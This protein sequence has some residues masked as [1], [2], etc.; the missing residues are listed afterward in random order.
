MK[1]IKRTLAGLLAAAILIQVVPANALM[2]NAFAEEP[3]STQAQTDTSASSAAGGTAASST[4]TENSEA[5]STSSSAPSSSSEGSSAPASS[6]VTS[7]P[8][9]SEVNSESTSSEV[10][11]EA[12]SSEGEQESSAASDS[13][14]GEADP[15]AAEDEQVAVAA[16]TGTER[17]LNLSAVNSS[18]SDDTTSIT[19]TTEEELAKLSH[20]DPEKVQNL[21]ITLSRITG[22]I[23]LTGYDVNNNNNKNTT[24][25]IGLGTEEYPFRGTITGA[26]Q[27]YTSRAFFHVLSSKATI[28]RTNG[29]NWGFYWCGDGSAAMIADTY[30]LEGPADAQNQNSE[31]GTENATEVTLP[32]SVQVCTNGYNT[33]KTMGSLFGVVKAE[34]KH[35]NDTL[36][37]GN[38]ATY[39]GATVKATSSANA[40]LICGTLES[41]NITIASD[42]TLPDSYTVTASGSY[43]NS[44]DDKKLA[45]GNAGGLIG[46]MGAGTTLTVEGERTISAAVTANSGNAGGLVGLM[47]SGAKIVTASAQTSAEE[48]AEAQAESANKITLNTQIITGG[49]S[50]GGVV[51]DAADV[52]LDNAAIAVTSPTAKATGDSSN[53]GGLI[54]HY[55]ITKTKTST[56][57]EESANTAY[58]IPAGVTLETPTVSAGNGGN[59]GGYFGWLE[60]ANAEGANALSFTFGGTDTTTFNPTHAE[61]SENAYG[62]LAGKITSGAIANTVK[63]QN[64]T[65]TSTSSGKP[66]YHGGL[67]GELGAEGSPVYLETS[68][69][70]ITVPNPDGGDWF[71]GLVAILQKGSILNI[72]GETTVSTK[73]DKTTGT[74]SKGGGAVGCANEGSAVQLAGTTDFTGVNYTEESKYVQNVGW[75]LGNNNSALIYAK[76]SGSDSGWT[77][78]RPNKKLNDI[79]N[80]GQIIRLKAENASEDAKGLSSDL[81]QIDESSH[82]IQLNQ[83]TSVSWNNDITLSSADDFAL[84]SIAWN[85]RG[86]FSADSSFSSTSAN[87]K[88]WEKLK[89]KTIKLDDNIDLSGTGIL[90]L[91][92]DTYYDSKDDDTFTG[93][94]NGQSHT[95]TLAIGEKFGTYQNNGDGR[96][97]T[98]KNGDDIYHGALGIFAQVAGPTDENAA[99]IEIKNLTIKG[100]MSASN[101]S[102][103]FLMGGIAAIVKGNVTVSG[104]KTGDAV[105]SANDASNPENKFSINAY[106]EDYSSSDKYIIAGSL[107]GR[108]DSTTMTIQ[109][110]SRVNSEIKIHNLIKDNDKKD[111]RRDSKVMVGGVIGQG[112]GCDYTNK[113]N[114]IIKSKEYPNKFTIEDLTISGT[115]TAG[116][117]YVAGV[118]GFIGAQIGDID[119]NTS[120]ANNA[121]YHNITINKLKFDNFHITAN[122]V[123]AAGGGIMTGSTDNTL[124]GGLLASVL[125][126]TDVTFGDSTATS[127]NSNANPQYAL[128]VTGSSITAQNANGVGGLCYRASGKWTINNYGIDLSGLTIQA[129]KD[130]GLLV[131]RGEKSLQ[132]V[133]NGGQGK[134]YGGLYL[135]TTAYW[136][137]AYLVPTET[138]KISIT[139]SDGAFDEF[140]AYTS[141]QD[142]GKS[143]K[144]YNIMSN[145]VN[146]IVSIATQNDNNGNRKG[147]AE[148]SNGCTTYQNRT[149]YGK[150]HR[151]NPNSRYYYDL[152]QCYTDVKKDTSKQKNGYIDTPQELMLWSVYQYASPNIQDCFVPVKDSDIDKQ[153]ANGYIIGKNDSQSLLELDLKKYSYYPISLG[154]SLKIQNA[155]I[156][157][158]NEAIEEAETKQGSTNKT[159][160]GSTTGDA[161]KNNS[162]H[163]AM[164]C[165]LL[166]DFSASGGTPTLSVT[167][168]TFA[169]SVGQ[170]NGGSG[171]LIA[172][173][174]ENQAENLKINITLKEITLDGLIVT[175]YSD[176]N[177]APLLINKI[178]RR[179]HLSMGSADK[180]G[181]S[182][183]KDSYNNI[184]SAAAS[185]LIGD[186]GDATQGTQITM[187][188]QNIVLPD[189]P[190]SAGRTETQKG[191]FSR[192]TLL[193]S[194]SY[195]D[196]DTTCNATYNFYAKDDP[197]GSHHVTYGK[198]ITGT[199][200]FVDLQKWY[201]DEDKYEKDNGLVS[202]G[203]FDATKYLPYVHTAYDKTN[204]THEIKVNQRV[205]NITDGCGTYGHPYKITKPG[206]MKI[207]S[208]YMSTGKAR[209]EWKVTITSDQKTY[210]TDSTIDKTYQYLNGN[211]VQLGTDGKATSITLDNDAMLQ[212]LLNAYYT[213]EPQKITSEQSEGDGNTDSSASNVLTLPDFGGFGSTA[214]NP[215][216][217]VITSSSQMT[218]KLTGNSNPL[219][220]FSYGSVVKGLTIEYE[221]RE[222]TQT[223]TETEGQTTETVGKTLDYKNDANDNASRK[224][225]D[226]A[227]FGGVIGCVLGGDNIIDGVSVSI[228]SGWLTLTDTKEG[229]DKKHLIPVGGYV[230]EVAGG[231]VIFRNMASD[232]GKLSNAAFSDSSDIGTLDD[233]NTKYLYINPYV[234]RV[235]DGFAFY[236]KPAAAASGGTEATQAATGA[237]YLD[238]LENTD[239]N[240]KINTLTDAS[241]IVENGTVTPQNAQGLLV[242]SAIVNSGA[243][244]GGTSNAYSSTEKAS[245]KT[246]G[247]TPATTYTFV[248]YGKVRNAAY[249]AIGTAGTNAPSDF[250]TAQLDDLTNPQAAT[251]S[252]NLPYLITKY[253]TSTDKA[254]LFSLCE[255]TTGNNAPVTG[256]N[257]ALA[258]DGSFDMSGFGT[259]YQGIGGR[260]ASNAIQAAGT[261]TDGTNNAPASVVPEIASFNGNS[262]TVTLDMQV[263]EYAD[264]DF[265]AASVGGLFNLV[266]ISAN[267]TA[268]NLTIS[269]ESDTENS[270]VSLVYYDSA[271]T[272][273]AADSSWGNPAVVGV[274]GFAGS[275][276]GYDFQKNTSNEWCN[277]NRD[278][279]LQSIKLQ[280]LTVKGPASAG[281]ILGSTSR[282][283]PTKSDIGIM[284][285]K[286]TGDNTYC[287]I[288]YGVAFNDCSYSNITVTGK[289]AA[290]GFAGWLG[291]LDGTGKVQNS[292]GETINPESKVTVTNETTIAQSSAI[293][294]SNDGGY[295]GGLIGYSKTR[296]FVNMDHQGKSDGKKTT[297]ENVTVSGGTAAGGVIGYIAEKCYGIC[298]V[299]VKQT[300]STDTPSPLI[301]IKNSIQYF[302]SDKDGKNEDYDNATYAGG[303]VGWAKGAPQTWTNTNVVGKI[304]NCTLENV[305]INDA[306]KADTASISGS[307]KNTKVYI[308]GGMVGAVRGGET[309]LQS[310]TVSGGK[311]YGSITGG[312]AGQTDSTV[313]FDGCKIMGTAANTENSDTSTYAQIQG[314]STAGGVLGHANQGNSISV[315]VQS[316][317]VQYANIVGHDWGVGAWIGDSDS[318]KKGWTLYLFDSAVKDSTVSADGSK[319][320]EDY[321]QGRW[322]CGGGIIAKLRGPLVGS[323]IL[324]SNVTISVT[325][326]SQTSGQ[327]GLLFGTIENNQTVSIAG[328]SLQNIPKENKDWK[329][330]GDSNDGTDDIKGY[331]AFADYSGAALTAGTKDS[332]G[333]STSTAGTEK[334]LLGATAVSPYVVTNPKSGLH[335]W[336]SA[337]D[338]V[339]QKYLYGDGAYWTETTDSDSK[340]SY[341]T[342]A[343]KIWD[344]RNSDSG[345]NYAYKKF[346]ETGKDYSVTAFADNLIS[347][348]NAN[349]NPNEM[350][351]DNKTIK[352]KHQLD[353]DFPVLQVE[354]GNAAVVQNYLDI[355]TNGGFSAAN[356]L[357]TSNSQHVTASATVYEYKNGKLVKSNA[358]SA[359]TANTD[360]NGK[361]ILATTSDYDNT[362]DRFT[363]L[364]V[365]FTEGGHNYNVYVPIIVRR[366]LQVDFSATLS[367][368][369]N[370]REGDYT[371]LQSHVLESFGSTVTGYL[372]YT[373]NSE[374]GKFTEYGWQSYIDAGGDV[375]QGMGKVLR[376]A[377]DGSAKFPEGTQFTLVDEKT[378]KAYYYTAPSGGCDTIAFTSFTDST[379]STDENAKA[380]EETSIADLIG[381]KAEKAANG[382]FIQVDQDGKPTE[383]TDGSDASGTTSKPTVKIGEEYYRLAQGSE[384]GTHN[385]TVTERG[386]K[387]KSI[388]SESY[389]LVI[390]VPKNSGSSAING[391]LQTSLGVSVPKTIHYN[392]IKP[393]KDGNLQPDVHFNTAS[394]YQLSSGYVQELKENNNGTG[395]LLSGKNAVKEI[396]DSERNLYV[397]VVDTITFPNGQAYLDS[398]SEQNN[399][400]DELYLRIVG[401]L[402][403]TVKETANGSNTT[404]T[405][406]ETFPSGTTGTAEFYVYDD[407]NQYYKWDSTNNQ[408]I[409]VTDTD[410][411]NVAV[412]YTWTST[413]GNMELLLSEDGTTDNLISLQGVRKLVKGSSSD[414]S[415]T[416]HVRVKMTATIPASGIGV[417]PQSALTGEGPESY[418]KLVYT[419]QLSVTKD[420]LAYS[421]NRGTVSNTMIQYYRKQTGAETLT[422]TADSIDMLGINPLDKNQSSYMKDGKNSI[423]DTT[424]KYDL[425][426]LNNKLTTLKNSSGIQFTLTLQQKAA[427]KDSDYEAVTNA[428]EYMQVKLTS[429][430]AGKNE[431]VYDSKTGT[432][433]W[434]VK[435]DAY[436]DSETNALKETLGVFDTNI[437]TQNIQLLVDAVNVESLSHQY[438][439]YRVVLTAQILGSDEKTVGKQSQDDLI[440]TLAKIK[441]EFVEKKSATTTG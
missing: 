207:L 429:S 38:I 359:F 133:A 40:G 250:T 219:I 237:N 231:G 396:T 390:T 137:T 284:M 165:G 402:Q 90:G 46:A 431:L 329:L 172:G 62:G 79:G 308:T 184:A 156:H 153:P 244:S 389:F 187:T 183:E 316:C 264:D 325:K 339:T 177:Y 368:G 383:K 348:Y 185:S 242:L 56:E 170:I 257:I 109:D 169:G 362:R 32:V 319:Q 135:K 27:T 404:K 122:N 126:Q 269:K 234:G 279:T 6:E 61:A 377:N 182:V 151:T 162:Q 194:Y 66:K 247:A 366:M 229:S 367:Y 422:Y 405:S 131:C 230:G 309:K 378:G 406:S 273:A 1:K 158:Y 68:G 287:Q 262:A 25:F 255:Q 301:Q 36:K 33:K 95:L 60:L 253:C 374:N 47:A 118:G 140:V 356:A 75:M 305:Q 293:I 281:G 328:L 74:I 136:D 298:E 225:Y 39:T 371:N 380:Y 280:N 432:W 391:S 412:S 352:V 202:G 421:S 341:T 149:D 206:E 3:A 209:T 401:S 78:S 188:F 23:N 96:I 268:K 346:T 42:Y 59:S 350:N 80:Y 154:G 410:T 199:T 100:S 439:N 320:G 315:T 97:Y 263:K 73:K 51:G 434:T 160:T 210:H 111:A 288:I 214:G 72:Q 387:G 291:Y 204:K 50:A 65:V 198:E 226:N 331:I 411:G 161:A 330:V 125:T 304:M 9:A 322:P 181:I 221:T 85:S 248:K 114:K 394:T 408:W 166:Y 385:I 88:N 98:A 52:D 414:N 141:S 399:Q 299:T 327:H 427:G 57:S 173:T 191:I 120:Y 419:S 326:G 342:N 340:T 203:N 91:S 251:E 112:R 409:Q 358:T 241:I 252:A 403:N 336:E 128:S 24:E 335:V 103:E 218:L 276:V 259:G 354:K 311:L 236:E 441:T 190:Y 267:G 360:S 17:N 428:S 117:K 254:K 30:I 171:A 292:G 211:W 272:E 81:I 398:T 296:L 2:V 7:E 4:D 22:Q 437:L 381:A 283:A 143:A 77:Y 318:E 201:Y 418:S 15:E 147:V 104:V 55:K 93:S 49:A 440:Y 212:Y 388:Y 286:W 53:T 108:A 174:A 150:A 265:H 313:L 176:S 92:R 364:T 144:S 436:F 29:A 152:D 175:K 307:N 438:G 343:Q 365:T 376:F 197:D 423:I 372:K 48:G 245:Y 222:E 102:G 397:D 224:Y 192:A 205:A 105:S 8:A 228:E 106:Y 240:Y 275:L 375:A 69:V 338:T 67:V 369:T 297:L 345:T 18:W 232:A 189:T 107:F 249:D 223:S 179:T 379:D 21:T 34:E 300:S 155:K 43:D 355:V 430:G 138:G 289:I 132:A 5:E 435:K 64:F 13:E 63:I 86:Y 130:L 321:N 227:A 266:R 121:S 314:F 180:N 82:A 35:K 215:F 164:H 238:S 83:G 129:G 424:A 84:L 347:T 425:T 89:S 196:G 76:G 163:Y 26:I 31:A 302:G 332:D 168:V 119:N 71:G 337:E 395:S 142:R 220:G 393:D 115:I 417:I 113:D 101:A 239:K 195:P 351:E 243:A 415:S 310:C 433:S 261:Q 246:S 285:H 233:N 420:S 110:E 357:N 28:S 193:N 370:F 116:Q 70:N 349:Q 400:K 270:I 278:I 303:I 294:A 413:G 306:A 256:V 16:E 41:G 386:T 416:F 58:Q 178:Y 45:S 11:S 200:E 157:F 123:A 216:R 145:A 54:G 139:S 317:Q 271:G 353:S 282:K 127:A 87:S 12:A 10:T 94:L 148:D 14:E 384:E 295:A 324:F 392:L 146:G 44:D 361:V 19:V 312:M 124:C 407:S 20:V 235:L 363:L 373:Y 258:S 260:Y 382:K 217:G 334:D 323:N 426:N 290:G 344:N 213:I 167:N 99:A 208:E 159:T 186:V 277:S 37:I 274:G 134:F 333:N